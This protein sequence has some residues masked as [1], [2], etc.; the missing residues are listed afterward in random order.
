MLV[1]ILAATLLLRVSRGYQRRGGAMAWLLAIVLIP[2]LGVPL[3]LIFGGRKMLRQMASKSPLYA[4]QPGESVPGEGTAYET[5]RVLTG[6]GLPAP[7]D[8]N[9]VDLHFNG[10]TAYAQLMTILDRAEHTI[11]ITTF[12]L[13]RKEVGRAILEL[14][15]RKASEGVAIR[16][17][18][19][20]LG[21]FYT[22]RRSL[23]P[24]QR[25]G[26]QV[27]W[28]LPVLPLRRRWS[29]NLRNHR[30]IVVVD[31][32]EAMVGG[33]N[34]DYRFMGPRRDPARFIDSAV[35]VAGPSVADIDNVFVNDWH[36][37]TG[38]V[39]PEEQRAPWD[40]QAGHAQ[41]QVAP[42]GPD[43]PDDALSDALL[44]A[45]M[46][47][48]D[49]IWLVTPY[50]VPDESMLKLLAL[51]ARMGRDVRVIMPEKSN[52]RIA[53]LARGVAVR[54]LMA[55]GAVVYLY[56]KGMVHAKVLLFDNAVGITGSPNLD[57]RSLLLDF[58]IALFHYTE[59]EISQIAGWMETL[60]AQCK[61]MQAVKSALLR[62]WMEG[63]AAL[64]APLI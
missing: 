53:D 38:E 32:R 11:H 46:D 55:A 56:P 34:L 33:M 64:A 52:H 29:A 57:M 1:F 7:R 22:R 3:Y 18:L 48:S 5:K 44:T 2:Y 43:V 14:L 8:G 30:K 4:G 10:E 51:Q 26:G 17:L 41:V 60:M 16:L 39:V 21:C 40:V 19:D 31:G 45:S 50:F 63:M 58:E 27:G 54:E 12:I 42:S 62:E 25:A 15:T 47:V 20:S 6:L 24:L 23:R 13:G 37:T 59:S 35:F 36:F 49:R 9:R 28:F 61:P